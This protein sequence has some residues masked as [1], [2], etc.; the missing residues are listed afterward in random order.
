MKTD[1]RRDFLLRVGGAGVAVAGGLTA[2]RP[3]S[4]AEKAGAESGK[5]KGHAEEERGVDPPEDLMREHGVLNRILLIYEE[6]L[7]RADGRQAFPA[8]T[9][10]SA[11]D[12]VRR[13]IAQYHEKLEEEHLFPRF[14]KANKL[15]E[16]V[17]TLRQQHQAGRKLTDTI[18]RLSTAAGAQ[19]AGTRQQLLDG[20]RGFIR[21]YRPHE[22]REDTV[23]FPALRSIVKPKEFQALG[24]RFEDKEHELFGREGFEGV[25]A[26]V[27][28]L[29][30]ALGI[31][32]LDQF[33]PR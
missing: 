19:A 12:I 28:K 13:F 1:R 5:K 3:A 18:I 31:H 30:Q 21:M 17:A 24:E 14:E 26:Q 16:L 22:S 6:G 33:T 15:V 20:L 4:A 27:A 23:L 9:V 32:D 25:V 2:A 7:R 11:A 29:E 8:D 10:A